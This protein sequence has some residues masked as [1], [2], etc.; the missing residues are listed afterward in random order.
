MIEKILIEINLKYSEQIYYDSLFSL[1]RLNQAY[2]S[3]NIFLVIN[4]LFDL[5]SKPTEQ[6][7]LLLSFLMYIKQPS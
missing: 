6:P 3:N 4:K 2:S 7:L 1:K 5:L